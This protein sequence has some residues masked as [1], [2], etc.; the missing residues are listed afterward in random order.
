LFKSH[1]SGFASLIPSQ[2]VIPQT[3]TGRTTGTVLI[4]SLLAYR[5]ESESDQSPI[6]GVRGAK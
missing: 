6:A 4:T 3:I 5:H 2:S 1:A